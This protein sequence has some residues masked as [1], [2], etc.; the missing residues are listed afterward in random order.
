MTVSVQQPPHVGLSGSGG[1]SASSCGQ[2]HPGQA[3]LW[4]PEPSSPTAGRAEPC[5]LCSLDMAAVIFDQGCGDSVCSLPLL[6]AVC[7][8]FFTSTAMRP[9]HAGAW[10][11]LCPCTA[12]LR[13]ICRVLGVMSAPTVTRAV[14]R[15]QARHRAAPVMNPAPCTP[16]PPP[17]AVLPSCAHSWDV[18]WNVG[19]DVSCSWS[20]LPGALRGASASPAAR[21]EQHRAVVGAAA[22]WQGL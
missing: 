18:G 3:L 15:I 7:Y 12:L 2:Q 21:G 8:Y 11:Q 14:R 20:L 1:L 4:S 13:H 19:C 17:A 16:C 9:Q 22:P 6:S 5:S 10:W